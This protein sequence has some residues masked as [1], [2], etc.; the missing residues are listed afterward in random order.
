MLDR[1]SR[2]GANRTILVRTDTEREQLKKVLGTEIVFTLGEAKGLEF[3]TVL[4]W[5]FGG[6]PSSSDVWDVILKKSARRVHEARIRHEINSLYVGITRARRD[7]IVF[8]GAEHSSIWEGAWH[9]RAG[10]RDR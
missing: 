5:K 7:L 6:D 3:D 4:L 2:S 10:F 9:R 8:D 1:V